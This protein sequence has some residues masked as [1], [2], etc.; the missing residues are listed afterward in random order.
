MEVENDFE[1]FFC[2]FFNNRHI[3]I[4]GFALELASLLLRQMRG[5]IIKKGVNL[6][7]HINLTRKLDPVQ[8]LEHERILLKG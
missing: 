3:A 4:F 7:T 8:Y 5:N 1:Q 6:K 2:C